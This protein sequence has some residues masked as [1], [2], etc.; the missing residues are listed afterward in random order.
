MNLQDIRTALNYLCSIQE[1][2]RALSEDFHLYYPLPISVKEDL[3]EKFKNPSYVTFDLMNNGQKYWLSAFTA[4]NEEDDDYEGSFKK[5]LC[6]LKSETILDEFIKQTRMNDSLALLNRID[7]IRANLHKQDI[8]LKMKEYSE[9]INIC[10]SYSIH[11]SD[12]FER[13]YKS[14]YTTLVSSANLRITSLETNGEIKATVWYRN[15]PD[16]IEEK[17]FLLALENPE[18]LYRLLEYSIEV[19]TKYFKDK[20]N[21]KWLWLLE[22]EELGYLN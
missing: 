3:T 7:I 1:A 15:N 21:N 22:A 9:L 17:N 16:T 12:Y 18:N 11:H 10:E 13:V 8:L 4:D 20:E 2:E 6:M 14:F 19:I 5:I